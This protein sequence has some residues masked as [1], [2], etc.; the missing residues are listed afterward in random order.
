MPVASRTIRWIAA[1]SS[2]RKSVT[3]GDRRRTWS[4]TIQRGCP[5]TD[6]ACSHL[7]RSPRMDAGSSLR[8]PLQE[9]ELAH[10][11]WTARILARSVSIHM[12]DERE[13]IRSASVLCAKGNI[14]CVYLPP[15]PKVRSSNQDTTRVRC[16]SRSTTKPTRA[17]RN[18]IWQ[19]QLVFN[20]RKL[21]GEAELAP[22]P[23]SRP[24]KSRSRSEHP[25]PEAHSPRDGLNKAPALRHTEI[26]V[27][28]SVLPP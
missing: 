2:P 11:H 25:S 23:C 21:H 9:L 20:M 10:P 18:K 19:V 13:R 27:P 17:V 15:T 12:R 28:L 14:V 26:C 22:W 16:R 3:V 5:Q 1:T 4:P 6:K 8:S 7:R 24:T